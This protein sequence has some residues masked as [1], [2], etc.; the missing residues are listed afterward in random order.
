MTKTQ[1]QKAIAKHGILKLQ[2]KTKG[3]ATKGL[4]DCHKAKQLEKQGEIR[5]KSSRE[6]VEDGWKI[7]EYN[8]VRS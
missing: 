6:F 3:H 2:V 4:A 8:W 1:I 5:L 7:K